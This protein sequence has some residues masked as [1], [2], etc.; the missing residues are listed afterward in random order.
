[1]TEDFSG[2][3]FAPRSP[4]SKNPFLRLPWFSAFSNQV[5]TILFRHFLDKRESGRFADRRR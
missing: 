5:P 4:W 2:S 1:M 3:R